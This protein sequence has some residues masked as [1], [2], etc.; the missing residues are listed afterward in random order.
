MDE[1]G[2]A[3]AAPCRSIRCRSRATQRRMNSSPRSPV[4]Q[5]LPA[6]CPR[7]SHMFLSAIRQNRAG[8]VD[9]M[10]LTFWNGTRSSASSTAMARFCFESPRRAHVGRSGAPGQ[11]ALRGSERARSRI[12][13]IPDAGARCG[14]AVTLTVGLGN[15]TGCTAE[16][17]VI[18]SSR[19][20]STE[21][22]EAT[23]RSKAS[24]RLVCSRPPPRGA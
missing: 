3:I 16:S 19:L 23:S 18:A 13:R 17:R 4:H 11:I 21:N 1:T 20:S 5:S 12:Y 14:Q 24:A 6:M 10:T 9:L 22:S 2:D 7:G 15:L 8:A